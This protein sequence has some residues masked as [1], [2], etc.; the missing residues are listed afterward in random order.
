MR[1]IGEGGVKI[2]CGEIGE[3]TGKLTEIRKK[4]EEFKEKFGSDA[5]AAILSLHLKLKST[6]TAMKTAGEVAK[7]TV[8]Q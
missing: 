8:M 5:S 2:H 4:C 3:D 1:S 6:A 7:K